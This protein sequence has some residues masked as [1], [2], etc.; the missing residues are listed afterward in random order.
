MGGSLDLLE[1]IAGIFDEEVPKGLEEIR[2]AI[3]TGAADRLR[4]SAHTMKG[5]VGSFMALRAMEL[6]QRLE[7]MGETGNLEGAGDVVDRLSKEIAAVQS[8]LAALI[9]DTKS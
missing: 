9:R 6:A 1:E 8:E 4:R 2:E 3:Q 5:S 7:T